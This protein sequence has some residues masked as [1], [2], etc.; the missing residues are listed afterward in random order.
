MCRDLPGAS[1]FWTRVV[2]RRHLDDVLVP[3][4]TG[5]M[6]QANQAASGEK[7]LNWIQLRT[8]SNNALRESIAE[9]RHRKFL[10]S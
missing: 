10:L 9:S 5:G 2:E 4:K 6:I 3:D 7:D 1:V 8:W